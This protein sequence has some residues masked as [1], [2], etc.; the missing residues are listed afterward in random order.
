MEDGDFDE[1]TFMATYNH[2]NEATTYNED[3]ERY[4]KMEF[5][6]F[7]EQAWDD[8]GNPIPNQKVLS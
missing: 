6:K 3:D 8:K 5:I 2:E 7:A 4:I 1:D